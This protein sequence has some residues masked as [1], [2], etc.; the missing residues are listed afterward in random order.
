MYY[1]QRSQ[2]CLPVD[3]AI[4]T[5][6]HAHKLGENLVTAVHVAVTLTEHCSVSSHF[7]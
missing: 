2:N 1:N 7:N 4:M 3:V 5:W 6:L